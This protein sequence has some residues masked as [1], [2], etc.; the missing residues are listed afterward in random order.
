MSPR[1]YERRVNTPFTPPDIILKEIHDAVPKHLLKPNPWTSS[2]YVARDF[3]MSFG[4]YKLATCISFLDGTSFG[5]LLAD[6]HCLKL[7]KLSCWLAYWW[8]QGM[9][10]AGMFFLGHD[11]G[12]GSLYRS[13]LANNTVGFV[14]HTMLLSPYFS[15]RSTHRQHHK[16]VGS[17]ERDEVF[18]PHLRSHIQGLPP[19]DEATES[20]YVHALE[21]TPIVTLIRIVIMQLFGWWL[22]LI[23]NEMGCKIYPPWTNHFNPYG[24]L[25]K[26]EEA[27]NIII[28]D[29]GLFGMIGLLYMCGSEYFW[30]H[31]LVP[32]LLVNH[33]IVL[34]TFLQHTDPTLPHYRKSEWSFVRGVACT[35]DRPFLGWMGR[36]FFHNVCHDHTAHHFF[37]GAP[38]YNGPEITK[39]IK[40]VLKSHYN[41]DSTP[42]PE[43]LY[44]SFTECLFIN[45]DED[46]AF[47]RNKKGRVARELRIVEPD[48]DDSGVD[49]SGE[50]SHILK[51]QLEESAMSEI[52]LL[53]D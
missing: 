47:Y 13:A 29:A 11:A 42:W 26:K 53:V 51:M 48:S 22:Y 23:K 45:E 50:K 12:H 19:P 21:E 15:W 31:Y 24:P 18:V 1:D 4:L 10:W 30:W 46:I 27:S 20:D 14:V 7:L 49:I 40:K 17:V 37:S 9:I 44:R 43:A 5:Q 35:M 16:H 32:Y 3:I 33:W 25:F 52:S 6:W 38:F 34:V 28:T 2:M 41:Y 8:I 36:F 39:R